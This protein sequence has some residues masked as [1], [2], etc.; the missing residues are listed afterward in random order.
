MTDRNYIPTVEFKAGAFEFPAYLTYIPN[1]L[2]K[3]AIHDYDF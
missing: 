1:A 2:T 3:Y